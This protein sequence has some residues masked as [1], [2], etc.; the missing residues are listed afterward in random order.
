MKKKIIFAALAL[1]ITAIVAAIVLAACGST[2][3]G[4][5]SGKAVS[6]IVVTM[7]SYYEYLTIENDK[8]EKVFP[9]GKYHKCKFGEPVKVPIPNGNYFVRYGYKNPS[10]DIYL[11][12]STNVEVTYSRASVSISYKSGGT[13]SSASDDVKVIH[14][15]IGGETVIDDIAAT[16]KIAFTEID[17]VLNAQLK[18]NAAIAIFP[19]T[20]ALNDISELTLEQLSVQFV[21]SGK[22]TVVEKRLVE[23]L[24]AEYDFQRSGMVGEPTLGELLGAD[25]VIFSSMRGGELKS[26]V[27]DTMKR[28][29]LAQS[30]A[31][32]PRV[33]KTVLPRP[34][35]PPYPPVRDASTPDGNIPPKELLDMQTAW[36]NEVIAIARANPD[37]Q[38]ALMPNEFGGSFYVPGRGDVWYTDERQK[39]VGEHT[40]RD[41]KK[42]IGRPVI[43][44]PPLVVLPIAGGGNNE[45]ETITSILEYFNNTT[46]HSANAELALYSGNLST[47]SKSK[48]EEL[49]LVTFGLGAGRLIAGKVEQIGRR[50][51]LV[52]NQL[53]VI[54]GRG[55]TRWN[56]SRLKTFD[57]ADAL[58]LWVKLLAPAVRTD[59]RSGVEIDSNIWALYG[60]GI[61]RAEAESLTQVLITDTMSIPYQGVTLK[62][63][64]DATREYEA[65]LAELTKPVKYE[66]VEIANPAAMALQWREYIKTP[67]FPAGNYYDN[68]DARYGMQI[69]VNNA[70]DVDGMSHN[71]VYYF[72]WSKIGNRTR[73]DVGKVYMNV[74]INRGQ[75]YYWRYSIEFGSHDEFLTKM[76]GLS[77]FM[78]MRSTSPNMEILGLEGYD[79]STAVSPAPV[80][81]NFTKLTRVVTQQGVPMSGFYVSNAPVSQREY[82]SV[83]KQ[84]PSF[85]YN[86][87]QPVTNVS[88]ID[89]MIFCNQMSIRDGLEPAYL[90]EQDIVDRTRAREAGVRSDDFKSITRDHFA[91]GYRLTT[92]D[93]WMF[94]H[95]KT[96]GMGA[97]AEYVFDGTFQSAR[98]SGAETVEAPIYG[99]RGP[100]ATYILNGKQE[101]IAR[102][103]GS[104]GEGDAR[105]APVI[106]L[107]RPVFDYWKYTSGQ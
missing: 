7:V 14:E 98:S 70:S 71:Y 54:P 1:A 38:F 42:A 24:L 55:S 41:A 69:L 96:E 62:T 103:A 105:I 107:V 22:Y 27:V 25:A 53:R 64:V 20:A 31:V 5:A 63:F 18:P 34:Y 10:G 92:T 83:M 104:R 68:S 35:Y 86:L 29:T 17:T 82:E 90:I 13:T 80:P 26:W 102:T 87:A 78:L 58:E 97:L 43:E 67:Q 84:N 32:Q 4:K 15:F 76:R 51:F 61:D 30:P 12:G 59:G 44:V 11:S 75:R 94:A 6:E 23:E 3:G 2:G 48:L 21:N 100:R 106:R 33:Q 36:K 40:W 88:L 89:A 8:G 79:L 45:G 72:D 93:E 46:N 99:G 28:T 101:R 52:L 85:V 60:A 49:T 95:N 81:S 47:Y 9:L 39:M 37:A 65:A 16:A 74:Q 66:G 57:Y 19:V 50:N 77:L 73:L 91:T 56:I